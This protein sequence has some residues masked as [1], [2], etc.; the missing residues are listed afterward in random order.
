MQS[1]SLNSA[2]LHQFMFATLSSLLAFKTLETAMTYPSLHSSCI[3]KGLSG[4]CVK[5]TH[6][7]TVL[8]ISLVSKRKY[9]SDICQWPWLNEI[10]IELWL[11][12]LVCFIQL[13]CIGFTSSV[14]YMYNQSDHYKQQTNKH[15]TNI[16]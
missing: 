2:E 14:L 13:S 11:C 12:F 5:F 4:V 10:Q 15:L 16:I 3:F 8:S 1:L 7:V 6:F 9:K